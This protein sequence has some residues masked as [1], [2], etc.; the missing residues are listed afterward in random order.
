[1]RKSAEMVIVLN[2]NPSLT[3]GIQGAVEVEAAVVF[4]FVPADE[5]GM[6]EH[7]HGKK[8]RSVGAMAD[9]VLATSWNGIE[10]R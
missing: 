5:L 2:C 9:G 7:C 8:D 6:K 10:P 1:M 3:S 4:L